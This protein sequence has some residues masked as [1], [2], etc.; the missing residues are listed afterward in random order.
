MADIAQE[1][2]L[3]DFLREIADIAKREKGGQVQFVEGHFSPR[4]GTIAAW[5]SS[6]SLQNNAKPP[7]DLT[8]SSSAGKGVETLRFVY[9]TRTGSR[10]NSVPD[11]Q[12]EISDK[13][14][15]LWRSLLARLGPPT[16]TTTEEE[17]NGPPPAKRR[18]G[19]WDESALERRPLSQIQ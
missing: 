9:D 12:V 11:Q 5:L 17:E 3:V 1:A 19:K 7:L 14:W 2:R 10:D 15:T 18:R 16:T 13:A 4:A 8:T 6:A